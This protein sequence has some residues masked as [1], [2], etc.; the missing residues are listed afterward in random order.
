MARG[1]DRDELSLGERRSC[2]RDQTGQIE[3]PHLAERERLG[4]CKRPVPELR[5]G[6]EHL[7]AYLPLSQRAERQSG[8]ERS[9]AAASDEHI[10]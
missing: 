2:L 10:R 6:G 5:L 3:V 1:V 7:D 9:D 8:L 4:H